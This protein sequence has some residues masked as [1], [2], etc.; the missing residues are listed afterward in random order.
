ME[1]GEEPRRSGLGQDHQLHR[2]IVWPAWAG[3][4]KA[5]W[6]GIPSLSLY[7]LCF[8]EALV[9]LRSPPGLVVLPLSR[10]AL[11]TATRCPTPVSSC[12]DGLMVLFFSLAAEVCTCSHHPLISTQIPPLLFFFLAGPPALLSSLTDPPPHGGDTSVYLTASRDAAWPS[13]SI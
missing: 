9:F 4:G 3:K 8:V 13:T 12:S 1:R 5:S 10:A 6:C 7:F 2:P 11:A